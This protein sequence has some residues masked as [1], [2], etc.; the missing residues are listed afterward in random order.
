M[1]RCSIST[2][3][4]FV[5][6][7]AVSHQYATAALVAL[8][9]RVPITV[10]SNQT[11]SLIQEY[12]NRTNTDSDVRASD[13]V[14][15]TDSQMFLQFDVCFQNEY[16]AIVSDHEENFTSTFV[17]N[18]CQE[19]CNSN[20]QYDSNVEVL[21]ICNDVNTNATGS[22]GCINYGLTIQ[23]STKSEAES[24]YQD[25]QE[26]I[27]SSK[28]VW[29][30]LLIEIVPNFSTTIDGSTTN[31]N[32]V[33]GQYIDGSLANEI[34]YPAWNDDTELCNN[35]NKIPFYMLLD[36]NEYLTTNMADCCRKHYWWNVRGCSDP[37]NRPCP[38]GYVFTDD[39]TL[40][41][42]S[43]MYYGSYPNIFYSGW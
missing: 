16:C 26:N 38:N 41:V 37:S 29:R 2:Y 27:V 25:I 18:V 1:T 3:T 39:D 22:N 17:T 43:G 36:P 35:D 42:M 30:E 28:S 15:T 14:A 12:N 10:I 31:Q 21:G 9:P 6:G 32:V 24:I 13:A 4:S 23:A 8:G 34:W 33:V 19:Y 40:G 7:L 5:L 11:L 20:A